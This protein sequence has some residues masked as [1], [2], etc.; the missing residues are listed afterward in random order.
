MHAVCRESFALTFGKSSVSMVSGQNRGKSP[1]M[2]F[3]PDRY[4]AKAGLAS[5][6]A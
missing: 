1:A 3:F 2:A 4:A 6:A 5:P